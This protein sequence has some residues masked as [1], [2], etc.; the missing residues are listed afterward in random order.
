MLTTPLNAHINSLRLFVEHTFIG[1]ETICKVNGRARLLSAV[2]LILK[3]VRESNA[4]GA[5][6]A[7]TQNS[8]S[9]SNIAP[10]TGI[11]NAPVSSA[12]ARPS[13]I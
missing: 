2:P 7:A 8:E 10:K 6:D 5:D 11:E 4:A 12:H 3:C 1:R 13:N 9:N